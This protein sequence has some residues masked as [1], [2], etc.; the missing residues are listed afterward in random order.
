MDPGGIDK[1]LQ[2]ITTLARTHIAGREELYDPAQPFPFDIWAE[3]GRAG[4]LG[5]GLPAE[6]GGGGAGYAGLVA[7]SSAF[8]RAGR[9]PGLAS[10]WLSHTLI[11]RL[12]LGQSG[13]EAQKRDY[14][15]RLASGALTAAVAISEPNAGAH[16]KRLSATARRDGD[17]WVLNGEKA[18]LTNGPI[19]GLYIVLAISE[20]VGERKQ[21]SAFLVP[22]DTPGLTQTDAGSVDFLRPTRHGGLHLQEVH[23][24]ASGL[25]GELGD[26]FETISKPLREVEDVLGLGLGQ[27]GRAALLD[28]L[29]A[30]IQDAGITPS[31]EQ[32]DL[33]GGLTATQSALNILTTVLSEGLDQELGFDPTAPLLAARRLSRQFLMDFENCLNSMQLPENIELL[34]LFRDLTKSGGLASNVDRAKQGKLGKSLIRF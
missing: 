4:M 26:A 15:P 32:F 8:V 11:G 17:S 21:F 3:M 19:A 34:R 20:Q 24:P 14:L 1:V 33:L 29:M 6:Y 18:W 5:L 25:L 27:G 23:I 9:N 10:A 12:I 30:A 28:L 2:K 31:E 22:R 7:A 16:P 13:S